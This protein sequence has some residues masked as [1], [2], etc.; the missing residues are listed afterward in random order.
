MFV[1]AYILMAS[2]PLYASLMRWV[3]AVIIR[4]LTTVVQRMDSAILSQLNA[5]PQIVVNVV[6]NIVC[7]TAN[8]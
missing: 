5:L 7:V 4:L 1:E 6:V 8:T 2:T 3:R